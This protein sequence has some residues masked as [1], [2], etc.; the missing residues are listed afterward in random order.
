MKTFVMCA[1]LGLLTAGTA[2]PAQAQ[3]Q[4]TPAKPQK[5]RALDALKAEQADI[6]AKEAFIN[7]AYRPAT[8]AKMEKVS[9]CGV[10]TEEVTPALTV[11]LKVAKGMG[12]LVSFV[13][14]K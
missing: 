6:A 7:A 2:A 4:T 9:Y 1:C 12:L 8:P 14:P 11:Q 3:E 13:E 5:L 10:S